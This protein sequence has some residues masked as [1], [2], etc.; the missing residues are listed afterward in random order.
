MNAIISGR[1]GLAVMTEGTS[2]RTLC[3]DEAGGI[4]ER[5]I[6][7]P[8][9]LLRDVDDLEL[10]NGVTL[11]QV[12]ELLAYARRREDGL[13]MILVLL[14]QRSSL[15][16]RE[17][18]AS[19]LDE[20]LNDG[21]RTQE[22]VER[23]LYAVPLPP[24]ANV[25]AALGACE[26]ANSQR[27]L[28]MVSKL[29]ARQPYIAD[30][31]QQWNSLV[32]LFASRE[33][34]LRFQSVLVWEGFFRELVESLALDADLNSFV[35][36]AL[37]N[38]RIARE[39]N[40]RVVIRDWVAGWRVE[41]VVP[42]TSTTDE[43]EREPDSDECER[44]EPG[45]RRPKAKDTLARIARR[46]AFIVSALRQHRIG[47]ANQYIDD[48]IKYQKGVSDDEH[49][50]KS[51]C[52]LAVEARNL[53]LH[54]LQLHLVERALEFKADDIVAK[55][56]RADT[57]K[58]LNRL[59]EALEA[60]E[61]AMAQHPEDVVAMN[62]YAEVLK[63]LNR[64]P[65]A[66]EAYEKAMAQHPEDVV[67]KTGYAE[68]LKALN[69]LPEALEAYEK[70]MAQHPENAVAKTGASCVLAALGLWDRALVLL[71]ESGPVT[72]HD[73]IAYHVRGMIHLRQG[74][75]DEAIRIFEYGVAHNPR[76]V[77]REY[78]RTALAVAH[79]RRREYRRAARVLDEVTSPMLQSAA[80]I[81]RLHAFGAT[82]DCERTVEI[83]KQLPQNPQPI[84][85][86]LQEELHRRYV[87]FASPQHDEE[88]VL[89]KETDYILLAA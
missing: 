1:A 61:K 89:D 83:Y 13:H 59:P 78:F 68:V 75:I 37:S 51:L 65:E 10:F 84:L 77:S 26:Q 86:E 48:L 85:A 24:A 22:A 31:R 88:W 16:V 52:D 36:R 32:S 82:G 58:A 39:K 2:V 64:L 38:S 41:E 45:A 5:D 66:L 8:G 43:A 23:T 60:Y 63:A 12:R 81:L 79:L 33:D 69:R 14:G 3:L 55:S 9:H 42:P 18:A 34:F 11:D 46:K 25:D 7:I 27:S 80:N 15:E 57:L 70:A 40:H 17:E 6:P 76:L 29:I 56:Q 20:L 28:A 50:C 62:G 21:G 72:E 74:E 54:D 35:F 19:V 53:G 30:V 44:A 49:I 4:S 87:L 67:A 47:S 71:P 73:W